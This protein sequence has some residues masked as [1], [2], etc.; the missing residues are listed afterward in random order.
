MLGPVHG[1][2]GALQQMLGSAQPVIDGEAHAGV[3]VVLGTIRDRG[4]DP[5]PQPFGGSVGVVDGAGDR[6][7]ELVTA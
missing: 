3:E 2:V 1:D 5:V 6:Q 4:E 7:G